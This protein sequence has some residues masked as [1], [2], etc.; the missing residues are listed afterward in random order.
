M[1]L[2]S[3]VYDVT[4]AAEQMLLGVLQEVYGLVHYAVEQVAHGSAWYCE[5]P[6]AATRLEKNVALHLR[7][8]EYQTFFLGKVLEL[9]SDFEDAA[10]VVDRVLERHLFDPE[11]TALPMCAK[12]YL[13]VPD[14]WDPLPSKSKKDTARFCAR[15]SMPLEMAKGIGPRT[16]GPAPRIEDLLAESGK[17]RKDAARF[18]AII[19]MPLHMAGKIDPA[20]GP[21]P[22]IEDL[23]AE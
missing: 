17:S 1:Q 9:I 16:T 12:H 4:L 14:G 2:N 15:V 23:L 5:D 18:C 22:R 11:T 7:H 20:K 19:S 21:V 6:M 3:T 8:S 10:A 13:R